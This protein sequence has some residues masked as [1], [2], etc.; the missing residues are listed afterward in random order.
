MEYIDLTE[1]QG[2]G[3][4][5]TSNHA[6][7]S[8]LDYANSGHT[9]FMSDEKFIAN[10][11]IITVGASGADYTSVKDAVDSLL[12]KW[13]NGRVTIRIASGTYNESAI[14]F[15]NLQNIPYIVIEAETNESKPVLKFAGSVSNC[16]TIPNNFNSA[17]MFNN[18]IMDGTEINNN[19]IIRANNNGCT[20]INNCEIQNA[21]YGYCVEGGYINII[22]NSATNVTHCIVGNGGEVLVR[23]TF[24]AT[25]ATYLLSW[26]NGGRIITDAATFNLTNVTNKFFGTPNQISS[27]GYCITDLT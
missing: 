7:L 2:G 15:S 11:T 6:Q 5:G 9:G 20:L 13:S 4:G 24:T 14:N 18:L 23:G 3:G 8:N 16:I 19:T 22:N 26:W 17:I 21:S 25:N 1:E 27:N 10:N 12:G